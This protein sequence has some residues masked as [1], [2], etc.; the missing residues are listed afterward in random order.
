M[1]LRKKSPL[2]LWGEKKS[3][4]M[5]EISQ[6]I[7]LKK[8]ASARADQT[9]GVALWGGKKRRTRG[10]SEKYFEG[11]PACLESKYTNVEEGANQEVGPEVGATGGGVRRVPES[12]FWKHLSG[13]EGGL[14]KRETC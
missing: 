6:T 7:A 14:L 12:I 8:G 5:K 1:R 9:P 13:G 4:Q 3:N 10:S 11:T 2:L